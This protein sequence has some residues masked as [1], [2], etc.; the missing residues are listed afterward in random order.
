MEGKKADGQMAKYGVT[1]TYKDLGA[2]PLGGFTDIV[3]MYIGDFQEQKED[4]DFPRLGPLL[5]K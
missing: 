1:Q 2:G 5:F 4:T 3:M